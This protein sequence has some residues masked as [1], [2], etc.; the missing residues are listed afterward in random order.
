MTQGNAPARSVALVVQGGVSKDGKGYQRRAMQVFE[1]LAAAGVNVDVVAGRRR[2]LAGV[3]RTAVRHRRSP[4]S[5]L[6]CQAR[7]DFTPPRHSYPVF[8][9]NRT[10]PFGFSSPFAID[11]IDSLSDS[12]RSRSRQYAI[13]GTRWF[14]RTEAHR[15]ARYDH[16]LT[17]RADRAFAITVRDARSL[18][19]ETVVIPMWAE[20]QPRTLRPG[21]SPS[22]FFVGFL[23][24]PPNTEAA[25][26]VDAV[27]RRHLEGMRTAILGRGP[28]SFTRK[29]SAYE[30]EYASMADVLDESSVSVAPVLFGA[31]LQTK[32]LESAGLGVPVVVTPFV[33]EGLA[34]PLPEGI[35]VVEREASATAE[36][37]RALVRATVDREA[38]RAWTATHYGRG[39]VSAQWTAHVRSCVENALPNL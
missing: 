38:L 31:G 24:Y 21:T 22:V 8:F 25:E 29:L 11:F 39:P 10:V 35:V 9:M 14:W 26:W 19:P 6:A 32:V 36:A 12:Y 4:L 5:V 33:A 2:N 37:I 28:H 20:E 15:V 3:A 1:A 27:L 30:G 23:G 13:W 34:K 16:A 18:G 17:R 7:W